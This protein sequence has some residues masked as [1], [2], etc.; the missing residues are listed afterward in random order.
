MFYLATIPQFMTAG[1]PPVVMGLLLAGVHV[2]CG[3]L[4]CSALVLGGSA[5]GSRLKSAAFVTWL[6]RVTGG[7]LIAFGA[8][9]AWDVR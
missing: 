4:W 9:L 3:M 2:A 8:K 1:V 5:L 7:V 6:D